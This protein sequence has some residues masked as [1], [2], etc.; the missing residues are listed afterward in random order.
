MIFRQL[1]DLNTFTYTYLIADESTSKAILVDTVKEQSERDLKLLKEL[2]LELCYTLETHIHADHITAAST[3]KNATNCQIVY[4]KSAH[5]DCADKYINDEEILTIGSIKLKAMFTPGHTD[6]SYCYLINNEYLLTG[7]CLLVRACGRTDFQHGDVKQLYHSITKKLFNLNDEI[8]VYPAHDYHG[9]SMS[10]IGEEKNYNPRLAG[11]SE[12]GF[13]EIMNNL[14][15]AK[16]KYMDIAVP[17]NQRCGA[18][19]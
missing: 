8:K 3:L 7:D 14:N 16:P 12:Q 19:E 1:F 15:L 11:V 4:P 5:C 17:F 18:D 2:N 10:T 13:I 6:D 9:F